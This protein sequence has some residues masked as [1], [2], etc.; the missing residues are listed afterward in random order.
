MPVSRCLPLVL[1]AVSAAACT[2]VPSA[3]RY[4]ALEFSV[5]SDPGIPL[6]GVPV[7]VDGKTIGRSNAEGVIRA[8]IPAQLGQRIQIGH[9]CPSGFRDPAEPKMLRLGD[10]RGLGD[11]SVPVI[12][13]SIRCAPISRLAVIVIR[14]DDRPNLPVVLDERI[15]ARTNAS[16]VAHFSTTAV[17]GTE[18]RVRVDTSGHPSLV[19]RS[20]IHL[21]TMPDA[22]EIFFLD[23]SFKTK[24]RPR[25]RAPRPRIIKIE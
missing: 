20:P 18:L 6:R 9:A 4:V 17:A 11:A 15:V 2:E 25:S 3:E 1:G 16:G 24:R 23:Q 14:T 7:T 8:T 22:H 10:Y 21:F 12:E 13:L 5:E 19:P